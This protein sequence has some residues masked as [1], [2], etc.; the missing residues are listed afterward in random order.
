MKINNNDIIYLQVLIWDMI[1]IIDKKVVKLLCAVNVTN[2]NFDYERLRI[3]SYNG[4]L[5]CTDPYEW[6]INV[7][8][9][10]AYDNFKLLN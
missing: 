9:M 8:V 2:K 10:R 3:L 5:S 6:A 1:Y 7:M 4:L